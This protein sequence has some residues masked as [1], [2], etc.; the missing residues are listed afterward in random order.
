MIEKMG[1]LSLTMSFT[2]HSMLWLRL[3]QYP[4]QKVWTMVHLYCDGE[5]NR[6][7]F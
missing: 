2:L 6:Q 3:N 5:H 7:Q 4:I 1:M